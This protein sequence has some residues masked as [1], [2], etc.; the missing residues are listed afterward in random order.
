MGSKEKNEEVFHTLTWKDT[1]S[2]KSKV[3]NTHN[4]LFFVKGGNKIYIPTCLHLHTFLLACICI[5][6]HGRITQETN[7]STY[8]RCGGGEGSEIKQG[9][10][11][12]G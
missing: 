2:I 5:K 1:V 9:C 12:E 3:D 8:P 10:M 11:R 6:K 4:M 7:K